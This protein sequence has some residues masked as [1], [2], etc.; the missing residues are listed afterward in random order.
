MEKKSGAAQYL[1]RAGNKTF[2]KSIQ[3][4][5]M[6]K[7]LKWL[8]DSGDILALFAFSIAGA[9]L[10][11]WITEAESVLS[12]SFFATAGGMVG[13]HLYAEIIDPLIFPIPGDTDSDT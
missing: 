6:M 8:Y 11:V 13:Y 4:M 10:A 2:L 5:V 3:E 9:G 1:D 12:I 7:M